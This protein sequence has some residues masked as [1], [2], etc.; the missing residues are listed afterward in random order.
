MLAWRLSME[1]EKLLRFIRFICFTIIITSVSSTVVRG[2]TLPSVKDKITII[3]NVNLIPMTEN[4]VLKN[5]NVKIQNGKIITILPSNAKIQ[6]NV[7][8]IDGK[9]GFLMPGMA[10]M[11]VHFNE[12]WQYSNLNLYLGNGVTTVRDLNGTSKMLK[13]KKEILEKRRVG[14]NLLISAPTIYGTEPQ[15]LLLANKF[16]KLN[17]DCMKIYSYHNKNQFDKIVRIAK[18]NDKY[19]V[20]HI[21]FQLGIEGIVKTDLDEIA[22]IEEIAW[23]LADI[24]STLD[25]KPDQWHRHL[26]ISFI[27]AYPSLFNPSL[28]KKKDQ[29]KMKNRAREIVKM[30]KEK[31]ISVCTTLICDE[32]LML[33]LT[34]LDKILAY[35]EAKFLPEYFLK[36]IKK[37]TDRHVKMLK[38]REFVTRFI[39]SWCKLI[40][41]E[42]KRQN[43]MLV[44]G[45]DGG[46]VSLASIPGFSVHRE[47]QLLVNQGFTPYNALKTCTVNAG[48]IAKNMGSKN[49]FGTIEIGKQADLVLLKENPLKDIKNTK[50]IEGVMVNGQWYPQ[51]KLHKQM[52]IKQKSIS[53]VLKEVYIKKGMDAAIVK[54]HEIM[55]NN[56]YNNYSFDEDHLNILGYELLGMGKIKEAI[57]VLKL[58]VAAYPQSANVY[59]SLGEAYMKNGDKKSA[60]INYEKVLALNKNNKNARK[61]LE[62]LKK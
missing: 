53:T 55:K 25:V 49:E 13:W 16:A 18:K 22:H 45:T 59:D 10:D 7:T 20:A 56:K 42:L 61:M 29:L 50:G 15:P 38:G 37:G 12:K 58:N 34:D 52:E 33:K 23:F 32:N 43:V 30:I 17:F 19:T 8:I 51:E 1:K 57:E 35:P 11:H 40:L 14:P 48:I 24:D 27:K 21:P 2:G 3:K 5:Q 36:N 46:V 4:K 9:N 54:Y 28:D 6:K 41:E 44:L 60:I 31:N 62:E 26:L 47:L 39:Y